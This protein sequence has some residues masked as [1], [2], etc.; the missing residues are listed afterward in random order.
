MGYVEEC[1]ILVVGA[2]PAGLAI[3]A[4]GK[5]KGIKATCVEVAIIGKKIYDYAAEKPVKL[6]WGLKKSEPDTISFPEGPIVKELAFEQDID[7]DEL[8][9]KY[10]SMVE[11][12]DLDVRVSHEFKDFE[13]TSDDRMVVNI[14]NLKTKENVQIKSRIVVMGMGNSVPRHLDLT[15]DPGTVMRQVPD[16][17][18]FAD[19]KPHMILGG[20]DTAIEHCIGAIRA[21]KKIKD[22]SEIFL[23]YRGRELRR[24]SS[25]LYEELGEAIT[26]GQVYYYR[27]TRP[28]YIRQDD[29]GVYFLGLRTEDSQK[30]RT[31]NPAER[32]VCI[33]FPLDHV[34][35]CI[36]TEKPTHVLQNG[37]GVK[38][39]KGSVIVSKN[40]ESHSKGV[41]VIGDILSNKYIEA[42]DLNNPATYKEVR[43]VGNIK[44]A[45]IDG[46]ALVN[47]L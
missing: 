46:V 20:G 36:G 7:K 18:V 35:A 5:E 43:H 13:W 12:H 2:G 9:R 45:Y 23:C 17:N 25:S 22:K 32:F 6:E 28:L 42:E 31:P 8:H 33:E 40:F 14:R 30:D 29:N 27:E 44:Q 1:D 41:Y 38:M 10:M 19:G 21:K 39:E 3:M 16:Y 34:V 11:T 15:G 26:S 37:C 24:V 47:S 4:R